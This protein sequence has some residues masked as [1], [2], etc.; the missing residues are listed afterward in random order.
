MDS[1]HNLNRM[2]HDLVHDENAARQHM[3]AHGLPALLDHYQLTPA[4]KSAFATPGWQSFTAIGI[5]PIFQLL[6]MIEIAPH[7]KSFLSMSKHVDRIR[8]QI[9]R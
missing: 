4:Q 9:A 2:I 8:G 7:I 3:S 6:L 1:P 5:P